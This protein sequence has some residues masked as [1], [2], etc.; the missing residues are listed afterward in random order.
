MEH[1]SRAA[2]RKASEIPSNDGA[3]EPT[4]HGE[5]IELTGNGGAIEP[6]TGYGEA[7]EL[8]GNCG[9]ITPIGKTAATY[10]ASELELEELY[11][12]AVEAAAGVEKSLLTEVHALGR[13][14]KKMNKPKPGQQQEESN[15]RQRLNHK[16]TSLCK[17]SLAYIEALQ[18]HDIVA[19]QHAKHDDQ[20]QLAQNLMSKVQALGHIPRESGHAEDQQATDENKLAR[21]IRDARAMQAFTEAQEAELAQMGQTELTTLIWTAYGK[22]GEAMVQNYDAACALLQKGLKPLSRYDQQLLDE[23]QWRVA[24]EREAKTT[25]RYALKWVNDEINR[26]TELEDV[27]KTVQLI[28]ASKLKCTCHDFVHWVG[29]WHANPHLACRLRDSGHHLPHCT[30]ARVCGSG[31]Q[32]M[33]RPTFSPRSK[34]LRALVWDPIQTGYMLVISCIGHSASWASPGE[35]KAGVAE[36]SFERGDLD[37]YLRVVPLS[38]PDRDP[39]LHLGLHDP[40]QLVELLSPSPR[41]KLQ[42]L[43]TAASYQRVVSWATV[44]SPFVIVAALPLKLASCITAVAGKAVNGQLHARS[45]PSTTSKASVTILTMHIRFQGLYLGRGQIMLG[46]HSRRFL[47]QTRV[48][49]DLHGTK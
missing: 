17:A 44:S 45:C 16:R 37:G 20:R 42:S 48:S 31:Q 46:S 12:S 15:L 33:I 3:T 32:G 39:F 47:A 13:T 11:Q 27:K 26:K 49:L 10:A 22:E 5:A 43:A 4:G 18:A 35:D 2:K 24:R 41:M 40:I 9:A 29:L 30:L 14:P 19:A 21:E 1:P 38:A 36:I 23:L 28:Q 34:M 7:I 25:A 8:K 6:T